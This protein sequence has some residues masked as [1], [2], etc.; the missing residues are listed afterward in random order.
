MELKLTLGRDYPEEIR[1]LRNDPRVKQ[2]FLEQAYITSEDQDN[3]MQQYGDYY[4]VCLC[5]NS[6]A[7]YVGVIDGD[8]RVCVHPDFQQKGVGLFLLKEIKRMYPYAT[9]QIKYDNI[10]S[11]KLFTKAE[12]PF[13]LI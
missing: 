2:G 3:Y 7:G 6:F 13:R 4:Y 1:Q 12:I 8:I 5:D 9:A 11:I 10:A